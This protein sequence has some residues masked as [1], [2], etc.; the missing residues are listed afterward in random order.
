MADP[1]T[2]GN[3]GGIIKN[4]KVKSPG[5]FSPGLFYAH[6]SP[7]ALPGSRPAIYTPPG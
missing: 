1:V 3:P 2:A 4:Y 7:H 6:S 5:I